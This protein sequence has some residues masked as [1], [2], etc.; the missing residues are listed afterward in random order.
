MMSFS[1]TVRHALVDANMNPS[2]LA[3]KTGYSAM[4]I[5]NLLNGRRR[6]NEEAMSKVCDALDL[7][8]KIEKKMSAAR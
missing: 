8:L 1:I 6:W 3:R 2:D 5:H 4:Y 7:E